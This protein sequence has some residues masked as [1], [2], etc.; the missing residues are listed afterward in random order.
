MTQY[1]SKSKKIYVSR[2]LSDFMH[3]A[4]KNDPCISSE[5]H[6]PSG[7]A[8]IIPGFAWALGKAGMYYPY[9]AA[10][11]RRAIKS[12]ALYLLGGRVV[13][14]ELYSRHAASPHPL[15]LRLSAGTQGEIL[16]YQL[17]APPS[18]IDGD[19]FEEAI[20]MQSSKRT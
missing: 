5:C 13:F 12:D 10:D 4:L 7:E 19:A 2:A 14:I 15:Y 9:I 20:P 6:K 18:E 11:E 8:E 1:T 16:E 3:A 17:P